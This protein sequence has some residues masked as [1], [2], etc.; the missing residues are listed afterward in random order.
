[1][2][3]NVIVC[4]S[5]KTN[6]EFLNFDMKNIPLNKIGNTTSHSNSTGNV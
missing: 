6:I 5:D 3:L 1:M 2:H 4:I